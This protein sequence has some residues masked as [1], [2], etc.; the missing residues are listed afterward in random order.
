M[1]HTGPVLGTR[2]DLT[3]VDC[4]AC[5]FAHLDPLPAESALA[6]YYKSDFWQKDKPGAYERLLQQAEWWQAM[7][8]DWL[9][10]ADPYVPARALLDVGPGYGGFL[11]AAQTAGYQRII[12][13]E[14]S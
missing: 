11:Q 12:G 14:P 3:V 2:D 4:K 13:I 10:L 8:G 6:D 5:G 1:I 9:A 7:Y